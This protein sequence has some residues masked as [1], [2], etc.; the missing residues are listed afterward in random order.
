MN[1]LPSYIDKYSHIDGNDTAKLENRY[2]GK[3]HEKW[4][5]KA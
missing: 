1:F 4:L 3:K 2:F 5:K